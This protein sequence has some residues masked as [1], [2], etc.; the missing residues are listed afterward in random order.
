MGKRKSKSNTRIKSSARSR[1][2]TGRQVQLWVETITIGIASHRKQLQQY[3][4]FAKWSPWAKMMIPK[5]QKSINKQEAQLV[6]YK[7][8]V[9][10]YQKRGL[11]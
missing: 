8:L 2:N 7:S 1:K 10:K 3:R 5:I 6:Y 9:K 4:K 11:I